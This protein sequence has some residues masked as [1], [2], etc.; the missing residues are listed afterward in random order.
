MEPLEDEKDVSLDPKP[1]NT[2]SSFGE[3][4][5]LNVELE[6]TEKDILIPTIK[7]AFDIC[8]SEQE[9]A[10]YIKDKFDEKSSPNWHCIVGKYKIKFRKG[11]WF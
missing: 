3:I 4:V 1:C 2:K 6:S 7:E 9:L 5:E 8:R 10:G 11:F